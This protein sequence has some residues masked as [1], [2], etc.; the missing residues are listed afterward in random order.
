MIQDAETPAQHS[1]HRA[2]GME[3]EGGDTLGS[4]RLVKGTK[5]QMLSPGDCL[6]LI[7]TPTICSRYSY[8][9]NLDTKSILQVLEPH[10]KNLLIYTWEGAISPWPGVTVLSIL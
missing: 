3:A 6:Q 7:F 1:A 9:A 5:H 10:G 2:G 8:I 4:S